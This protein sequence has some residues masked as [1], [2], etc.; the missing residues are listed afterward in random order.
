[1]IGS[2]GSGF[3]SANRGLDSVS[4]RV[5][6]LNTSHGDAIVTTHNLETSVFLPPN[7]FHSSTIG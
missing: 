4:F 2:F 5:S 7:P 3:G 1:M 6:R